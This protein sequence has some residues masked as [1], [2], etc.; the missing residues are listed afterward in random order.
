MTREKTPL[1]KRLLG[2]RQ[3]WW[4]YN[5]DAGRSKNYENPKRWQPNLGLNQVEGSRG[6]GNPLRVVRPTG[7]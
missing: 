3:L 5:I 2:S 1:E 6:V 7:M 4:K